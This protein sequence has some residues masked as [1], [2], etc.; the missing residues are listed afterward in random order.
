GAPRTPPPPAGPPPLSL[1]T[2]SRDA[3][4]PEA[5]GRG[6]DVKL[7]LEHAV[8]VAVSGARQ[9]AGSLEEIARPFGPEHFESQCGIKVRGTR[10]IGFVA[11]LATGQLLGSEGNLLRINALQGSGVSVLLRLANGTVCV[12]PV[13]QGFLSALTFHEGDLVD[14]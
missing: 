12:I 10:I 8:A 13:I 11:P 3:I 1:P 7:A 9:F 2:V 4:R 14:V 5:E 6:D